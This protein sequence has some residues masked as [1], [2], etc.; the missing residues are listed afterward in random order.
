MVLLLPQLQGVRLGNLDQLL[1]QLMH[2]LLEVFFVSR[3]IG[4]QVFLMRVV[5]E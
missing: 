3:E 2:L 4:D 5:L 1:L